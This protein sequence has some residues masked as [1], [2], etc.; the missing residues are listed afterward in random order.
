MQLT[1]TIRT[2]LTN[3]ILSLIFQINKAISVT[4]SRLFLLHDLFSDPRSALEN[5]CVLTQRCKRLHPFH[6][7]SPFPSLSCFLDPALFLTCAYLC[8][9]VLRPGIRRSTVWTQPMPS[10]SLAASCLH[11]MDCV[12]GGHW[13]DCIILKAHQSTYCSRWVCAHSDADSRVLW[14]PFQQLLW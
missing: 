5:G 8:P 11:G 12:C 6:A 4:P 10:K 2:Y 13:T 9:C 14:L 1:E 3:V 7:V